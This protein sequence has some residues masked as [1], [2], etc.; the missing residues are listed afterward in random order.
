MPRINVAPSKL[1]DIHISLGEYCL[2][3]ILSFVGFVK[4]VNICDIKS[5]D[6]PEIMNQ[7]QVKFINPSLTLS[8]HKDGFMQGH[9]TELLLS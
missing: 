2:I 7:I 5:K 9:L 6:H 4:S 1:E 3:V 8:I